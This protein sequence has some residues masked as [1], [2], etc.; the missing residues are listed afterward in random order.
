[1]QSGNVWLW[2]FYLDCGTKMNSVLPPGGS[3]LPWWARRESVCLQCRR[4]GFDPW[5]GKIPWRREWQPT[6]LLLP[7]K[8]HGQRSLVDYRPWGLKESDTTEQLHF[9]ISGSD[10]KASACSAE[11]PGS[12]T[13]SGRSPGEGNGHPLQYSCL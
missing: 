11:D 1:M 7:V 6:P 5:V 9:T 12:I 8:S 4:P 10:G 3:W 13:G 2:F